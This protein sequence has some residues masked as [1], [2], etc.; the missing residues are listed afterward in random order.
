MNGPPESPWQESLPPWIVLVQV[1]ASDLNSQ[2]GGGHTVAAMSGSDDLVGANDGSAAHEAATHSTGQHDLVGELSRVGISA[3]DNPATAPGQGGG[4][5]LLG[6][7]ARRGNCKTSSDDNS[8]S[9][10]E[11]S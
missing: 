4:E 1:V 5:G 11:Y 6:E 8:G 9:H 7:G 10:G 3:S 2:L